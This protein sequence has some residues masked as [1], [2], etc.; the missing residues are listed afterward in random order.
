VFEIW[1]E[2]W[3]VQTAEEDHELEKETDPKL[4]ERAYLIFERE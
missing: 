2:R 1:E 3:R 4:E